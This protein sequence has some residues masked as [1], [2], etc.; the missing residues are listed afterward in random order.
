MRGGFGHRAQ[1]PDLSTRRIV[2]IDVKASRL[3][4]FQVPSERA[5]MEGLEPQFLGDII[6]Q[7]LKRLAEADT[8]E[9]LEDFV[10]SN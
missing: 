7:F 5:G 9:N 1:L 8:L 4:G 10:L 3:E 6:V 2:D